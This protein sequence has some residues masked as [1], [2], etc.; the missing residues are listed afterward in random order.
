MGPGL[1]TPNPSSRP[2]WAKLG[3][4]FWGNA[5]GGAGD[6]SAL[7]P[8]SSPSRLIGNL[9]MCL[10]TRLVYA[11]VKGSLAVCCQASN[12]KLNSPS[13]QAACSLLHWADFLLLSL[14]LWPLTGRQGSFRELVFLDWLGLWFPTDPRHLG[15]GRVGSGQE[16]RL[17][18]NPEKIT[19]KSCP[20]KSAVVQQE[21][22]FNTC[23]IF[24]CVFI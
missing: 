6:S 13:G 21:L 14:F 10:F 24:V 18:K 2:S 1:W 7:Q 3:P 16:L 20:G 11:S 15:W 8:F 5:K 9:F 17:H 19:L 12:S 23:G 4:K 22:H